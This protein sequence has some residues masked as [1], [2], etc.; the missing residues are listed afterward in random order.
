MQC[1]AE[2]A[3]CSTE[4]I[5]RF[6]DQDVSCSPSLGDTVQ[7]VIGSSGRSFQCQCGPFRTPAT[8]AVAACYTD[9]RPSTRTK[10]RRAEIALRNAHTKDDNGDGKVQW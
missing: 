2:I 5:R 4:F 7:L 3:A 1:L 6:E 10:Q 9:G 8:G